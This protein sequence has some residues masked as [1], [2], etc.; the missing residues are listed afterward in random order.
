MQARIWD[1][2]YVSRRMTVHRVRVGFRFCRRAG[3]KQTGLWWLISVTRTE[4]AV[5]LG[6]GSNS[7]RLQVITL[8]LLP[9]VRRVP[10]V[11][12]ATMVLE[13]MYAHA[14]SHL[15]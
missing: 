2:V 5:R 7:K 15:I 3:L 6:R 4:P 8:G 9:D 10:R 13:V 12:N 1:D 11:V 14:R